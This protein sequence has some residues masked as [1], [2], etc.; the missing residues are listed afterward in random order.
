MTIKTCL[1]LM[2]NVN[3]KTM[4]HAYVSRT[5]FRGQES[6]T[7][8]RIYGILTNNHVEKLRIN[9]ESNER[10]GKKK[11]KSKLYAC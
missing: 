7:R 10:D 6:L 4:S 3:A 5:H 9:E 8:V 1:P 11:V 2:R